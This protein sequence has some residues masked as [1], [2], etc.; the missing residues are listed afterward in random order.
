MLLANNIKI[1]NGFNVST[2]SD[3]IFTE[4]AF[5]NVRSINVYIQNILSTN[6]YSKICNISVC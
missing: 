1:P 5:L 6:Q 2:T 3:F 4:I